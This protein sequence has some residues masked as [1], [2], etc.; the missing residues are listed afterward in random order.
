LPAAKLKDAAKAA[1]SVKR[2][3]ALP[4]VDAVLVGD[5]WPV[6]RGGNGALRELTGQLG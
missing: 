1:E 6:F 5:G 4:D 2:L 3:A